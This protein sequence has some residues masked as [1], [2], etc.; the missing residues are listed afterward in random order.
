MAEDL[1]A[2]V[3]HGLLAHRLH[4]AHL[5]ILEQETENQRCNKR[6][7]NPENPMERR[8]R[9]YL[10]AQ[11]RRDV[12]VNYRGKESWPDQAQGRDHHRQR[13]RYENPPLVR[14]KILQQPP[15]QLRVV[16][17]PKLFFFVVCAHSLASSSS[18]NC[19]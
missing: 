6:Q 19:F 5:A 13:K 18:S 4:N 10:V 8:V 16:Y 7:R 11:S 17:A 14:L 3:V 1:L 2:Q 15:R 12:A 9:R